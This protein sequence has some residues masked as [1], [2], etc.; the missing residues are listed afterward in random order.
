MT[1]RHTSFKGFTIVELL[2]VIVVI[3]ILAAITI[4]AYN[5]IQQ[6]ALTTVL[7]TDLDN[8]AKAL[9]VVQADTGSYPTT[10]PSDLK[11]SKNVGVSLANTGDATTFCINA[12]MNTGSDIVRMYYDSGSSAGMATGVCSG[13]IIAGSESGSMKP[14][15][16][17]N[18]EFTSGWSMSLSVAGQAMTTRAGSAGD[19]YPT[20]PVL[21][22]TNDV[23]RTT[24]WAVLAGGV[25]YSQ[26]TT[27]KTYQMTYWVRK[28]GTGFTGTS[29]IFGV[30]DGGTTNKAIN[31]GATQAVNTT[32]TKVTGS[33]A[34]MANAIASNR[35]YTAITTAP[36]A[37]TGWT[38]EFQGFEL[39]EQ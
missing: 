15:L 36:F 6:R 2:I 25:N 3:G 19:P 39:T 24:S 16:I 18:P 23:A 21:V 17:S 37:T 32:W 38:L 35:T 22:W 33:S 27:G 28:T 7:T 4:V 20:K 11:L 30:M 31:T 13:A 29:N 10:F 1:T 26:I 34:A 9:R 5:G 12:Q 8:A 14:N